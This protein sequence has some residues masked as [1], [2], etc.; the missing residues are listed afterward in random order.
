MTP[1]KEM[2]FSL[3]VTIKNFPTMFAFC[4]FTH[5]N[6]DVHAWHIEFLLKFNVLPSFRGFRGNYFVSLFFV[7]YQNLFLFHNVALN[8]E[9]LDVS[10]KFLYRKPN[11]VE[12]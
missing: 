7:F 6:V 4:T 9:F 2:Q 3:K 8:N 5:L 11:K 10:L 1:F 12:L